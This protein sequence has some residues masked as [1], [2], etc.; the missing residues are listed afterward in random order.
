MLAIATPL[1]HHSVGKRG[2]EQLKQLGFRERTEY[3]TVAWVFRWIYTYTDE[4]NILQKESGLKRDTIRRYLRNGTIEANKIFKRAS[5]T[6]SVCDGTP[7]KWAEELIEVDAE[8][9]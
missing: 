9:L 7:K 6:T 3:D 1:F 5:F 2:S 8:K 4:N